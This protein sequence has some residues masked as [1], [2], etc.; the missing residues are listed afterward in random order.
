MR[1]GSR[2]LLACL[3]TVGASAGSTVTLGAQQTG[4]VTER[5]TGQPLVAAQ[6]VIAGTTR[7]TV[8]QENGTYRLTGV[9]AGAAQLRVLRIGYR[10]ATQPITVTAG[11]TT[12]VDVALEPSAV[13]LDQVVVSATGATERK[14]EN[15]N[16]VGIIKPGEGVSIAA[17]PTLSNVL[18]GKTPGLTVTSG[19]GNPGTAS[20][21]RIRGSNS[22]S[23][24]NE[25]LLIIDGV[26]VNNDV[27]ASSLGVGGQRTSRFDD[28]NPED[29]ES[30][31]VLKGPAASA[32]YGTAAANG[33]IQI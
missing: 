33:V 21:I 29:I 27:A 25:P 30:I 26:R 24:S 6:V 4:I 20:R 10:A 7:G 32:L 17:T 2:L 18:T 13:S 14:R 8:T 23:L 31:E 12:T 19:A 22:V 11:G 5:G 1:Y 9:P 28:I 15:G 3:V 16:D